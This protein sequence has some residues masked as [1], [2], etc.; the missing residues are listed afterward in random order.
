MKV[1]D[2]NN[3]K[4]CLVLQY[5][6]LLYLHL[7]ILFISLFSHLYGSFIPKYWSYTYLEWSLHY[8]KEIFL[9]WNVGFK[10]KGNFHYVR[11]VYSS[12]PIRD[13]T[14]SS[15]WS[16]PP[17]VLCANLSVES[18]NVNKFKYLHIWIL[19]YML[20]SSIFCSLLLFIISDIYTYNLSQISSVITAHL[21]S[22]L[23]LLTPFVSGCFQHKLHHLLLYYAATLNKLV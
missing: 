23:V 15:T 16:R 2:V 13:F 14:N 3:H 17:D 5:F 21:F 12:Q 10:K 7:T 19:F 8:S 6:L 9:C 4:V 1:Q 11:K 20:L 18:K 22:L